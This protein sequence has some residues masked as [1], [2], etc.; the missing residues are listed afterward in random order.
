M[1]QGYLDAGC[2]ETEAKAAHWRMTKETAPRQVERV[3]DAGDRDCCG[4]LA[5]WYDEGSWVGS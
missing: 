3:P 1:L 4:G 5:I 2:P